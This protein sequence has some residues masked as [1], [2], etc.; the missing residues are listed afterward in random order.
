MALPVISGVVRC[1]IRQTLQGLHP[2]VNVIH[3]KHTTASVDDVLTEVLAAWGEAILPYQSTGMVLNGGKAVTMEASPVAAEVTGLDAP[4]AVAVEPTTP[5]TAAVFQLRTGFYGRRYRGRLYLAGIPGDAILT[6][7]TSKW[8][9]AHANSPADA[10]D[11]LISSFAGQDHVELLQV[12]SYGVG[13]HTTWTPFATQV[14]A[15]TFDERIGTQ[16]RRN[17]NR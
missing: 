4:G 7:D 15:V 3:V 12:A 2:C 5:A 14:D 10:V 16:R 11:D 13:P 9:L 1:E 8:N 6:T 17:D